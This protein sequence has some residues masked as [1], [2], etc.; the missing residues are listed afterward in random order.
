MQLSLLVDLDVS[1]NAWSEKYSSHLYR[2]KVCIVGTYDAGKSS[3]VVRLM[4][5]HRLP[6]K[7]GSINHLIQQGSFIEGEVITDGRPVGFFYYLIFFNIDLI[8][9]PSHL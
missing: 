9:S 8:S 6:S 3:I 2:F 4:V 5:P 7:C 1:L